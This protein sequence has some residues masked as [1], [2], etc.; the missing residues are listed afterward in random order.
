MSNLPIGDRENILV[1]RRTVLELRRRGKTIEEIMEAWNS[2]V[3]LEYR[4]SRST[5]AKDLKEALQQ[6]AEES[7]SDAKAVREL[8]AQRLDLAM[9]APKFL[10]QIDNGNLGAIDKLVR[11][12]DTYAKLYG[13]YAPTKIAQ[14]DVTGEKDSAALSD[15]ERLARIADMIRAAEERQ[16]ALL[17]DETLRAATATP[18]LLEGG[19]SQP[20]DAPSAVLYDHEANAASRVADAE[21]EL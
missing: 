10:R 15:D 18:I 1:R 6:L 5:I 17:E 7:A 20:S 21:S 2:S 3:E 4:V 8:L 19:V 13:A 9:G 11:M 14:T 12:V 16:Q